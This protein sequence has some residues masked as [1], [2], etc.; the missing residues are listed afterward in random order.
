[1]HPDPSLTKYTFAQVNYTIQSGGTESSSIK[2]EPK[3]TDQTVPASFESVLSDYATAHP[4][5]VIWDGFAEDNTDQLIPAWLIVDQNR[6]GYIDITDVLTNSAQRPFYNGANDNNDNHAIPAQADY[7]N[8]HVNGL[9]DLADF[10]PVFLN[11]KELLTVMPPSATVKYKLK[12]AEGK[13]K[14]VYTNLTR[15]S[16]YDYLEAASATSGYG[17]NQNKAA[18]EAPTHAITASGVDIFELA[19]GLANRIKNDGQGVIL[20]ELCGM[21]AA[22]LK[23]VVEKNN[24]QIAEIAV[25][26]A[27]GEIKWESLYA[28]NPVEDF[29][30]PAYYSDYTTK[31]LKWLEG[32][33]Y[34]TDGDG[35]SATSHRTRI[36]VKVKMAGAAGKR[37]KLKAFDVDDPTP[38]D[39]DADNPNLIDPNDATSGP[40]GDDNNTGSGLFSG[41]FSTSTTNTITTTLNG[42]GEATVEFITTQKPGSNYRIL[43]QLIETAGV[44]ETLQVANSTTPKYVYADNKPIRGFGGV[45]SPTLTIWRKLYIEVDSMEAAPSPILE[46]RVTGTITSFADNPPN[47]GS[48]RLGLSVGLP[49]VANRFEYGNLSVA[50]FDLLGKANSDN[51]LSNDTI[52]IYKSNGVTAGQLV[53]QLFTLTD[54]DNR[55]NALHSW[56]QLP[57]N[58]THAAVTTAIRPKYAAAYVEIIDANAKGLNNRPTV[59]FKVNQSAEGAVTGLPLPDVYN[60]SIDV[61]GSQFFWTHAVVF[62]FQ[63][64]TSEDGDPNGENPPLGGT[65]VNGRIDG[66]VSL[67][68]SA[69]YLEPIRERI[70]NADAMSRYLFEPQFFFSEGDINERKARYR[71]LL[72]GTIAHEIGHGPSEGPDDD[73]IDSGLMRQGGGPIEMDFGGNAILRF[74]SAHNWR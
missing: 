3:Q 9:D 37:V 64:K 55:F 14:F 38:A 6:D 70:I 44:L 17:P 43:G 13:M 24:T 35:P 27:T 10:F 67:G 1:M 52:D 20:M 31:D 47:Y 62:G 73:H 50:G 26:I 45:A 42:N 16:A 69:I 25:N 41:T 23:L 56:Q 22:P 2:L 33:R 30:V 28:D 51:S 15:T 71:S 57:L 61:E 66:W 32:K 8:D 40:G 74:R 36:N 65:P 48:V 12:Q 60:D 4:N 7:L 29:K 46:N 19:P 49:D 21:T 59:S 34:F 39:W 68:Y 54:D 58:N 5:L 72:L 53:G 11:I 63:P 18:H